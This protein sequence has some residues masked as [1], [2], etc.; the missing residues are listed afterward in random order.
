MKPK[1]T[2]MVSALVLAVLE[3]ACASSAQAQS[4]MEGERVEPS[5]QPVRS[6][7]ATDFARQHDRGVLFHGDVALAFG[8]LGGNTGLGPAARLGIGWLPW[9]Q[10]GTSLDG[11]GTALGG[12]SLIAAGPALRYFFVD[13]AVSLGVRAG[14]GRLDADGGYDTLLASQ[15]D[16]AWQPYISRDWSLGIGLEVGVHGADVDQNRRAP[17][18]WVLGLRLGTTF[19]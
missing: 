19:N 14:V 15:L 8:S 13:S 5:S 16:V 7:F 3:A 1:T 18:G 2:M 6:R 17:G 11:W 4:G 9:P 10:V 12:A